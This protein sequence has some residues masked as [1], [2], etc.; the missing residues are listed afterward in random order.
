MNLLLLFLHVE[1]KYVESCVENKILNEVR[2]A[3][4]YAILFDSTP[5]IAHIDQ[6]TEII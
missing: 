1:N 6:M 5:D 2:E 3:K 4:Y